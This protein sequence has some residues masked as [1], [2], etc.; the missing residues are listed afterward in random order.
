[1]IHFLIPYWGPP[2]LLF[3]AVASVQ[4]Q[5]DPDWR[6]T[7]VDD[8]WPDRAVGERIKAIADERVAYVRNPVN[9]GVAG[10]FRRCA[11]LSRGEWT[12]FLGGDDRLLPW[13]VATIREAATRFPQA[14]LIQ[15]EVRTIDAAGR[16]VRGLA[17]R[18]KT[19]LLAPRGGQPRALAGEDLAASLLRGDWLYW[20]SLAF[21]T[22]AMAGHDFRDE[23]EVVLDLAWIIDLVAAGATLA[24][25]PKTAFEYRRHSAS[26]SSDRAR[27]GER[28]DAD[29]AYYR[30]AARQMDGLGWHR[31]ARVARRRLVPRLHA[32]S[33]LPGALAARDGSSA[34]SLLR[35]AL[36]R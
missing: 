21:R 29:R 7:V 4:A 15:P 20:P 12:V 31:A 17:D 9:L 2:D 8:A 14:D 27:T 25:Y 30:Q 22:A 11:E 33:L 32:L 5:A 35:H 28:F 10:N 19:A 36:S 34:G 6:L 3:E 13:Y 16:P 18:V 1:M 24:Y 23:Y 26:V